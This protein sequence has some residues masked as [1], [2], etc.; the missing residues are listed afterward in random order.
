M[1]DV[2][3]RR[4]GYGGRMILK[5]Q[6]TDALIRAAA[7]LLMVGV[8]GLMVTRDRSPFDSFDRWGRLGEDW[9]DDHLTL[10]Q[11]LRVVEVS[12]ATI[13]MIVLV[14]VLSAVLLVRRRVTAT[15]FAVLV[16]VTTSLTTTALKLALARGRPDWQDH[17]DLL[18]TKSFPSG[19][20]SSV[21]ACAGI[22]LLLIWAPTARQTR[23]W[24]AT[25]GV[26]VVWLVVCLDR[27]LLGRHFPSD[28]LAGSLLGVAVVLIGVAILGS[29]TPAKAEEAELPP[30]SRART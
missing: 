1:R 8:I 29:L 19:H 15:V 2:R 11:V 21:A 17:T 5:R 30:G 12:F 9:A 28:V 14:T 7:C 4:S 20:A 13:G 18:S 6:R 24:P 22:L 10:V 26:V 3:K 16:M 25:V 27:V 23:R